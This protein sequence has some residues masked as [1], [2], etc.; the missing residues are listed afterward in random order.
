MV[1][2]TDYVHGTKSEDVGQKRATRNLELAKE[3]GPSA[4]QIACM[5]IVGAYSRRVDKDKH[6]ADSA[7]FQDCLAG[8]EGRCV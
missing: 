8:A 1:L 3:L 7:S 2:T 4:K 6:L 5:G